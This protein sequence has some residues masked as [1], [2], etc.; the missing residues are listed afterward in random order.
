MG[1][2]SYSIGNFDPLLRDLVAWGLVTRSENSWEL[3][4][5][6]QTRLD[7]VAHRARPVSVENFVYLDHRCVRCQER[8]PTRLREEGYL[9]DP[10]FQSEPAVSVDAQAETTSES[11][12]WHLRRYRTRETDPLAG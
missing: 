6:A 2:S 11:R 3:V 10:C 9:C 4:E 1:S 8:R 7:E 12:R 5:A